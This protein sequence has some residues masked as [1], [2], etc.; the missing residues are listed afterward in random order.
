MFL[1]VEEERGA[2]NRTERER[3][4]ERYDRIRPH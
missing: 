1:G 2:S 4:R 3:E